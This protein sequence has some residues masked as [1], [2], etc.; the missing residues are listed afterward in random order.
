MFLKLMMVCW[1]KG[2]IQLFQLMLKSAGSGAALEQCET[3][4]KNRLFLICFHI[5][6]DSPMANYCLTWHQYNKK[7]FIL[8]NR[9]I[10]VRRFAMDPEPIPWEDGDDAGR[11]TFT[12][13]HTWGQSI[14]L[15]P[16][17][18]MILD[19]G[20]ET[21][22]P[23]EHGEYTFVWNFM[24]TVTWAEGR[25]QDPGATRWQCYLLCH[26][27]TKGQVKGGKQLKNKKLG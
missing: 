21:G 1:G 24:Q 4:Y 19:S 6:A 22:S 12:P 14:M 3:I 10:L 13:I 23:C 17:S 18:C 8:R 26:N 7:A 27:A 25:T 16:L 2:K 5:S 9:F 15:N 11:A 20:K